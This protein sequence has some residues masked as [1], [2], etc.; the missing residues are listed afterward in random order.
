[1]G[2]S[3]TRLNS[4]I[5]MSIGHITW[6]DGKGKQCLTCDGRAWNSFSFSLS[7]KLK[8]LYAENADNLQLDATLDIEKHC[9]VLFHNLIALL[10]I[11]NRRRRLRPPVNS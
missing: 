5:S 9:N 10:L 1:M 8:F 11:P 4:A 7:G 3:S 2:G 6:G